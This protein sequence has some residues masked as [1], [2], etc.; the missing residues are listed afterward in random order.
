M[1]TF[2]VTQK[3]VDS[4]DLTSVCKNGIRARIIVLTTQAVKVS[5]YNPTD[6]NNLIVYVNDE[7]DEK[8]DK[9]IEDNGMFANPIN[10]DE[11]RFIVEWDSFNHQ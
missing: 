2:V 6:P 10:D 4:C 5:D 3:K 11:I 7:D 1:S 8:F 9:N